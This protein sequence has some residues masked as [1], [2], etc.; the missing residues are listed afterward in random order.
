MKPRTKPLAEKKTTR[1]EMG[2]NNTITLNMGNKADKAKR[3]M[4][5]QEEN[6]V[7]D[8][9]KVITENGYQVKSIGYNG[10]ADDTKDKYRQETNDY[11]TENEGTPSNGVTEIEHHTTTTGR[12]D[13]EIY[14][15][16]VT[17]PNDRDLIPGH[18]R[19][20]PRLKY[21]VDT[22][23]GT[24]LRFGRQALLHVGQLNHESG[25][26]SFKPKGSESGMNTNPTYMKAWS[27]AAHEMKE[28]GNETALDNFWPQVD[29]PAV[30]NKHSPPKKGKEKAPE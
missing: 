11:L 30:S 27:L 14:I 29:S 18:I 1:I 17:T 20:V 21:S 8:N 5:T 7:Q 4:L 28:Q 3:E 2:N 15:I 16:T 13:M 22:A 25:R 10:F 26:I 9:I 6:E 12:G 19:N 23:R 24:T